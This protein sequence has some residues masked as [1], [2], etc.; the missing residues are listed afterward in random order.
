MNNFCKKIERFGKAIGN[1]TRYNI[2]QE[3]TRG[4]RTVSQIIAAVGGSQSATSQHLKVLKTSFVV[5]DER[6][7]QEVFYRLNINHALGLLQVMVMDFKKRR[8]DSMK[9]K[10]VN[11]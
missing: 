5:L 4:P 11:N 7:G 9:K 10:K 8:G 2:V 1:A 6:I 3:L